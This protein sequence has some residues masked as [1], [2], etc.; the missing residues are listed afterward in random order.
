M[1]QNDRSLMLQMMKAGRYGAI[2]DLMPGYNLA[3]SKEI[4][5]EMGNKWCCHPDNYVKR[6]E[7]PLSVLNEPRTKVLKGRK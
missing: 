2:L 4:I 7:V 6:L 3:K 1:N 5:Q